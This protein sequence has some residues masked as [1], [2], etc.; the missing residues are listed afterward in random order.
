MVGAGTIFTNDR[1]PRATTPDL[2]TLRPS[3]PDERTLPTLVGEGATIGAGSVIGCDLTIGRFAMV[4]MGSVVT[5]SAPPF[6]LVVGQPARSVA[7]IS[8]VGSRSCASPARAR[9][10]ARRSCARSAG[11]ATRSAPARSSSSTLH[12]E[13]GGR[14]G[15]RVR[16][17]RG[18]MGG[19][20]G[21]DARADARPAVAG[22]GQAGDGVR[23]GRSVGGLATCVVDRHAGRSDHLGPALPR[24]AALGR[25]AAARPRASSGSTRRCSG[26]RRRPGTTQTVTSRSVSNSV[27]FLKLP[28][29]PMISKLRL[30]LTIVHGSRVKDWRRL[31]QETGRG[32]AHALVG[33]RDVRALLVA[34][35]AGQ[36]RREL[37]GG[38]RRVHLGDDP[39]ALRGATQR[40]EEGDVRLR[41]GGLRA[42]ARPVRRAP[43]RPRA[44]RSAAR[45]R[46]TRV[47]HAGDGVGG[48]PRR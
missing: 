39:A 42:R 12:R 35:A 29:L 10:I 30:A 13:L 24:H 17:R 25:V 21:R 28:G 8:R 43:A 48:A 40:V 23:A 19:G 36:A 37:A 18:D 16:A 46:S 5:R 22:A 11:S 20:R 3:E 31:E 41:A 32:V 26:W 4:G 9:P 34:A 1:Y 15:A 44:W 2:A 38:E 33:P 45:R 47:E 7:V 6:H 14:R 27:E